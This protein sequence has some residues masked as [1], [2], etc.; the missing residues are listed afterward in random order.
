MELKKLIDYLIANEITF[1]QFILLCN[2]YQEQYANKETN[3]FSL[4][5]EHYEKKQHTIDLNVITLKIVLDLIKK[6][7]LLPLKI[8]QKGILNSN[9][10][11]KTYKV[12][13]LSETGKNLVSNYFKEKTENLASKVRTY[14]E[15]SKIGIGG[16]ASTVEIVDYNLSIFKDKYYYNNDTILNACEFYIR[17]FLQTDNE[18]KYITP[19]DK[20]ITDKLEQYCEIVLNNKNI[21]RNSSTTLI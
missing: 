9:V 14:W 8:E 2:L 1:E 19:C 17:E 10:F 5:F 21:N 7:L 18:L 13:K 12:L 15:H 6:N 20:F 3:I 16:K 4:L 11:S